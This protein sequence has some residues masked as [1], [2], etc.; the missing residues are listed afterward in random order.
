MFLSQDEKLKSDPRLTES[1]VRCL[2][3]AVEF[4]NEEVTKARIEMALKSMLKDIDNKLS[5]AAIV[6]N[7]YGEF[8]KELLEN[9]EA[10]LQY[11]LDKKD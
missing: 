9:P 6:I 8:C 4:S 3:I 11:W 7:K 5:N 1:G 2:A 10:R